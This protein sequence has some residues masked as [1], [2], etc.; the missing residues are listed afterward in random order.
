MSRVENQAFLGQLLMVQ[1]VVA[2]F[3]VGE[4]NLGNGIF[5]VTTN[6]IVTL[7]FGENFFIS[8]DSVTQDE[9]ASKIEK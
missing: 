3:F 4:I 9:A 8:V 2:L 7:F 1:K 5:D 6:E